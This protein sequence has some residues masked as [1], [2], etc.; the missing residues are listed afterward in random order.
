M[1]S[2]KRTDL[3]EETWSKRETRLKEENQILMEQNMAT[4]KMVEQEKAD[5]VAMHIKRQED[6]QQ[7]KMTETDRL[8]EIHR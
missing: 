6:L 3:I 2:R 1:P 8:K 5:L 7:D 4:L